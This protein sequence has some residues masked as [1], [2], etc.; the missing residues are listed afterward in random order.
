MNIYL[1][2]LLIIDQNIR[3][4]FSDNCE[5]SEEE[6][7]SLFEEKGYVEKAIKI[8]NRLKRKDRIE[9][10]KRCEYIWNFID[11]SKYMIKYPIDKDYLRHNKEKYIDEYKKLQ[12][13]C[14]R[15]SDC[16]NTYKEFDN[17]ARKLDIDGVEDYLLRHMPNDQLYKLSCGTTDWLQKLFYFSYFKRERKKKLV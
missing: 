14:L 17:Y 4:F 12:D 3:D 11:I 9:A 16:A 1:N 10:I 2:K 6:F 5:L 7:N 15:I 8:L 13:F